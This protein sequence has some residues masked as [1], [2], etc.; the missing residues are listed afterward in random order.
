MKNTAKLL[1]MIAM[2]VLVSAN[3]LAQS[4]KKTNGEEVTVVGEVIDSACYIKGGMKGEAHAECATMCATAGIPLAILEDKTGNV[5]FTAASKDMKDTNE[6]L[7]KYVAEKV[8]VT[9]KFYERGGV[10]LLA[11]NMVEKA[12]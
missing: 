5:Y 2:A 4:K 11:I 1:A 12:N 9:G 8:K 7:A 3:A 10:K 6:M